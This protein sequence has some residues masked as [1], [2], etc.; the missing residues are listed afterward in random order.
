M[1]VTL[2]VTAAVAPPPPQDPVGEL[3]DQLPPQTDGNATV[4]LSVQVLL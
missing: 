1:G 4:P 2:R 3:Q